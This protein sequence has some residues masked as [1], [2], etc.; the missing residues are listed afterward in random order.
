[1]Y[2]RLS[3]LVRSSVLV[4]HLAVLLLVP[5]LVGAA[6]P[7][8]HAATRSKLDA[9]VAALWTTVLQTPATPLGHRFHGS[10]P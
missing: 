4:R 10:Q 5:T 1:M 8:A 3:L 7:A 6:V 2:T 9:T